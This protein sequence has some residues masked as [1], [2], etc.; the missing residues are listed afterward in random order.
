MQIDHK[1]LARHKLID[2]YGCNP[3]VLSFSKYLEPVMQ[4]A[5]SMAGCAIIAVKAHQFNPVGCTVIVLVAESHFSIHTWPEKSQALVDIFA[6]GEA[7]LD[8]AVEHIAKA[9]G[10]TSRRVIDVERG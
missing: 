7:D 2:F 6:S 10:A 3:N 8:I 1:P 9:I 5:A 4:Q